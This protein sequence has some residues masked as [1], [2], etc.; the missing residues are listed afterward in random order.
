MIAQPMHRPAER[1]CA[2]HDRRCRPPLPVRCVSRSRPRYARTRRAPAREP[3]SRPR[4]RRTR[5]RCR[6]QARWARGCCADRRSRSV[7]WTASRPPASSAARSSGASRSTSARPRWC[8]GR[9]PKPWSRPRSRPSTPVGHARG[10][11]GSP[12]SAPDR[13]RCCLA[14]LVRIA[15]CLRYRH[16]SRR[17]CARNRAPQR[18]PARI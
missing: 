11:C 4:P 3:R 12:I 5:R 6:A 15:R 13:A 1:D 2:R 10:P 14:L 9:K 8:R 7:D 18:R 17:G 16:R